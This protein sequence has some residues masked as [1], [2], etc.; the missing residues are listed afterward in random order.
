M[1]IKCKLTLVANLLIAKRQA[2][3]FTFIGAKEDHLV[4]VLELGR[5]YSSIMDLAEETVKSPNPNFVHLHLLT[6]GDRTTE[7]NMVVSS[8]H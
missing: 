2:K 4:C 6:A 5:I 3:T 8:S 1:C 7:P